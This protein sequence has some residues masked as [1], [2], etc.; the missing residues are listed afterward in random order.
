MDLRA[1][2]LKL[3]NL[4]EVAPEA[5]SETLLLYGVE[6]SAEQEPQD[7]ATLNKIIVSQNINRKHKYSAVVFVLKIICK[8]SRY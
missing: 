4:D 6:D 5:K 8:N 3:M 2:A 7:M 1:V